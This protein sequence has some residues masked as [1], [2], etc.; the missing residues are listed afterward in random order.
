MIKFLILGSG[1]KVNATLVYS[2]TTLFQIDMGIPLVRVKEGLKEIHKNLKDL[3][4]IL[5]THE[6]SDHIGTLS[7][8]PKTLP[9]YAGKGTLS[10][11]YH[12]IDNQ[13]PFVIGDFMIVPLSVSHDAT[14]PMGFLILHD[15]EKLV[16]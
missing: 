7:L 2:E 16:Y 4:A 11:D 8:L 14:N 10:G 6:H 3:Q 13:D 9:I 5:I 12:V 1:S 15:G